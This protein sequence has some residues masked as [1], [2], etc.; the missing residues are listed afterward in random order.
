[1][2]VPIPAAALDQHIIAL[3]KTGSGKSSK[4]RVLVEGLL[5][6]ED[7]V[8]I[9]DPKG[10]WWGLKS[11]ADGK[12]AGFP[13]VIFGGEHADV[14]LNA[15]GG[16][17]VA[18]L[19][20]TGNR[21]ALIDLGG[22][23]V[24]E[25]TRFF[26]DFAS[27]LFRHARGK[28]HLVIDEVHNFAPQG[29]TEGDAAKALHWANRLASE[30][31]GKGIT[32]LAASQRPQKVHK[33]LVTSCETLIACRVIHKL[34]RDAIK[35]WIDG[36]ADPVKGRE[37]LQ[38]LASM[39]RSE[40]WVWSPEIEFGPQRVEWPMFTT[41]DSFKPQEAQATKLK[42]WAEVDLEEVRG[43]LQAVVAEAE[44]NDPKKLRAHIAE[45]QR[46]LSRDIKKDVIDVAA[47]EQAERHGF[48]RGIAG[49]REAQRLVLGGVRVE[50]SGVLDTALKEIA[51][52][53]DHAHPIEPKGF[54]P[55]KT[56]VFTGLKPGNAP[57][58]ALS[59]IKRPLK[60]HS[61]SGN[62]AGEKLS[63]AER[64]VLT[65]LAQYPD[66]RTKVQVALLARYAHNGGG[67]NN[68]LSAL[69]GRACIADHG[70]K[71]LITP[72]GET[73]LGSF[74]PLPQGQELLQHWLGQLSKAEREILEVLAKEFP[75]EL[76]KE[77]VAAA[78]PTG[79]EPNGGGF[80]NALSRLRT[81]ELISGRGALRASEDLF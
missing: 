36:C 44:A 49:A 17:A 54:T 50:I 9:I 21:P 67:F 74:D 79:Y 68:A 63:K 61:Y 31:R 26:V 38:Q 30:G 2:K 15:H 27:A 57:Q 28:R 6:A 5:K 29:R 47:L 81:L 18:E 55:V 66:G 71:L 48:E 37:V 73:A 51:R 60:G 80:N 58:T 25:R 7:P 19:I 4:L 32:L 35:D 23:M 75:R 10:D 11:S 14:P 8:C 69:R 62:G 33:D 24:G 45:L 43:K 12:H 59:G 16:A 3:G 41:Y 1:M 70:D 77:E 53:F 42:G 34:D 46:A 65:A 52:V 39:P 78:T 22:W 72:A 76:S 20:A 56:P 13:I 40:A 64:L